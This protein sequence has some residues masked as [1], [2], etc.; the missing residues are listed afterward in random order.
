MAQVVSMQPFISKQVSI[1]FLAT[2]LGLWSVSC[3]ALAIPSSQPPVQPTEVSRANPVPSPKAVNPKLVDA[4]TRFGFKLFQAIQKQA[5]ANEN[6][7]ISPPSVAIA[8]AMTYNGANGD[9]QTAMNQALQLNGMS[10]EDLN[11]GHE[12]LKAA[13][14]GSDPKVN[15]K[16]ANSLWA[17]QDFTFNP[18]F[19]RQNQNFYK[20]RVSRLDFK[21]PNSVGRVNNWVRRNTSGKIP[22]ILDRINPD[23]LLYL[24]N[25]VYFK[26]SWSVP[27]EKTATT[28]KLFTLANGSTKNAPLMQRS[29]RL[30]YYENDQ[31]QAVSLPYGS[32]RWSMY[33]FLPNAKSNLTDFNKTL[34]NENWDK[35]LN[36]F[37]KRQ[38]SLA[39]PK[40]KADFDTSLNQA[41][42]AIGMEPA[43]ASNADF[44][45]LS[46]RSAAISQVKHKTF[47]EVNEEGT[48]AAAVTA[49]GIVTT[50]ARP[51]DEPFNMVV[52]RPF[53]CAIRDNQTGTVLFMGNIQDP[54]V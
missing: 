1:A 44:S 25:A 26:G 20:A 21:D 38:G 53:F 9:T 7:L 22:K 28:P 18:D 2:L 42:G 10:L 34:T 31:F 51:I 30:S 47:V 29:A 46:D 13:L 23:E 27:F 15:L 33:V 54:E 45:K 3:G 36:S 32:G 14:E 6:T 4:N 19:L 40:F 8:L 39:L 41:L 5:N 24:V 48:E 50:S 35:W 43:F 11:R 17:R 12:D 52:D 37:Q 16:I 49:V